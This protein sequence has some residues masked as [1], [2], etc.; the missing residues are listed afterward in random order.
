LQ[1]FQKGI[2]DMEEQL[3]P[4]SMYILINFIWNRIRSD[5][6]KRLLIIDEAWHMIQHED[7]GRFLHNITKRA[8]KYYLG[9]TTI[10]QDV[11]D[12]LDSK[13]GKPLITNSSLQILLRQAPVAME[14]LQKVFNLTDSEKYLLLNSGIGQGLFFAGNQHVAIQII[15]SYGENK[16]ITTN[17]EELLAMKKAEK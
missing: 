14:R 6:K 3:R 2:R 17:P 11:E 12:F 5:L 4:I 9:V 16:I 15:A 13:W 10:T 8:R 7:S 1:I